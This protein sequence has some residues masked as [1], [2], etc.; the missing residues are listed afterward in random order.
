MDLESL[1]WLVGVAD[2]ATLGDLATESMT[3]QPA[4]TRGLQRLAAEVGPP[5][6]ER[7]GRRLRLT[8]AG[9]VMTDASRRI[10]S[11]L[12]SALARSREAWDP[13]LG[14]IRFGFLSPL[15]SWLVPE[16]LRSFRAEK[17]K[18]S[19]QLRQDGATRI[20][21]AL[22]DGDLDLLLTSPP[23]VPGLEWEKLFDEELV[24]TVPA[25]HWTA[26]RKRVRIDELSAESW[27]LFTTGYG[28]RQRIEELCEDAGFSPTIAF[29][30]HDIITLQALIGTGLGIGLF[31]ARPEPPPTTKQVRLS[32]VVRRDIGLT[33]VAGRL[34]SPSG[35]AFTSLVRQIG[36]ALRDNLPVR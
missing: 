13:E 4:V 27:V 19:F 7:S 16:L 25:D 35:A 8:A 9:M 34:S 17:P 22:L 32:P 10:I 6:L 3:S 28:L 26:M 31:P 21:Q 15:G 30:G 14:T 29:E 1:R 24:L 36:S 12:D 33:S 23:P 20:L 18:V 11:D 2:G 5:L